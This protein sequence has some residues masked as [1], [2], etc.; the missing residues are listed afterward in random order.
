MGRLGPADEVGCGGAT[1][2]RIGSSAA[3]R[4]VPV[5]APE[6]LIMPARTE[7][8]VATEA[9]AGITHRCHEASPNMNVQLSNAH[10]HEETLP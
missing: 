1:G 10:L 3:S 4:V 2:G 5:S 9:L 7:G 8:L 6:A